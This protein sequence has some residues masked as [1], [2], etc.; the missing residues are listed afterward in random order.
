MREASC[1]P[2]WHRPHSSFTGVRRPAEEGN[3]ETS[4]PRATAQTRCPRPP[5]REGTPEQGTNTG[6]CPRREP[7]RPRGWVGHGEKR[8]CEGGGQDGPRGKT[9]LGAGEGTI[10]TQGT[11]PDVPARRCR[12]PSHPAT[13]RHPRV[14]DRGFRACG[15]R[16]HV[17][18]AGWRGQ[19]CPKLSRGRGNRVWGPG[20]WVC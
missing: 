10:E 9:P 6:R 19:W 20:R 2:R 1:S 8:G 5:G 16:R 15:G 14:E 7:R 12:G 3:R 4:G 13:R 11:R 18:T 17:R